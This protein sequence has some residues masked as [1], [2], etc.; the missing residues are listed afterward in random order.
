MF[1]AYNTS[2]INSVKR[3]RILQFVVFC[4]FAFLI[5]GLFFF[6]V[7]HGGLYGHLA[8]QNRLRIVRTAPPR[9]YIIDAYGMPLAANVR[10]FNICG[11]PMDLRK[12]DN[13]TVVARMMNRHGIPMTPEEL[14]K[15][16]DKQYS[17]PYR[18]VTVASNL[19]FAQITEL[20]TEKNF[21]TLLFPISVWRRSY[22]R[23]ALTAHAVGYI[24]E[25]TKN[26]LETLD[27]SYYRGGDM[28]GKNGI[29]AVYEEELRGEFG[30]EII[31]V[32][33]RGRKLRDISS[34]PQKQGHNVKLTIDAAA[35]E[36]AAELMGH[37]RGALIVMDV[38][39][40]AVR[41]L[42]SSPSYDSNLLT[43]GISASD[44]SRLTDNRE[45]P[46]MNR[47]I[48]SAYPPASTFKVITATAA[49]ESGTVSRG[50]IFRCPG[51]YELGNRRFRCWKHSGHGN[52][53]VVTALRDS[54]DVYFYEAAAKMGIDNLIKS[55]AKYG[56]G[57]KTGIDITSEAGGTIAGREWKEKRIHE[58]WYGGD[59]VNYSIG[60]GYVLMTPLQVVRAYAAIANGGKLLKPRI[61]SAAPVEYT[62]LDVS[63]NVLQLLRQGLLEVTRSGTG[64]RAS[65]FGVSVAGKTGTAQN[66]QG[67]D[68]AWFVGYAPVDKPKYAAVVIAEAGKGGSSVG[69]PIVGQMLNFLIN[70]SG[71]DL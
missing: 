39:T 25:I 23:G 64:K 18:A 47:A 45:R 63:Q 37:Y 40:G 60:Q 70:R 52:E 69:G 50:T 33:S 46:M 22:P 10:T 17:A 34:V 51:Y 3:I 65:S 49:L 68:H 24:A 9:G 28:I 12:D 32:D 31:E 1:K 14:Q 38:E 66:S 35:Q 41:C 7:I 2:Q 43:W 19:T 56:V 5:A 29:E 44:W 13:I 26:E 59:T 53:N 62:R 4:A 57:S 42:Y 8:A 15:N 55:A 11:Y 67:D 48:S 16:V 71:G 21:R 61:N 27:G 36:Y 58:H 54:C 30:E 20:V 6:Q